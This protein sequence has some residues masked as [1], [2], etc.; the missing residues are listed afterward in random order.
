MRTPHHIRPG[1]TSQV[2]TG[3]QQFVLPVAQCPVQHRQNTIKQTALPY[4]Q[5]ILASDWSIR[6]T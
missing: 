2:L 6:V 3:V 1:Q 4:T 5:V